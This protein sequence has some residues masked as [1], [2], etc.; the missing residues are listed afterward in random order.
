MLL[1]QFTT[2]C[3]PPHHVHTDI[4][5]GYVFHTHTDTH[6]QNTQLTLLHDFGIVIIMIRVLFTNGNT[7]L[8]ENLIMQYLG[9][10]KNHLVCI[11]FVCHGDTKY[12]LNFPKIL[13]GILE[14]DI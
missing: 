13:I 12:M 8:K 5:S 14:F 10:L 4:E 7:F 11:Y 6:T 1:S 9:C 3:L 2:L